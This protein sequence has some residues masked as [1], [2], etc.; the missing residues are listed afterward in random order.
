MGFTKQKL[1]AGLPAYGGWVM[2]AHP[3]IIELYAGEHFDWICLDMEHTSI[4]LRSM[5]ECILAAKGMEVDVLVR[6]PSHEPSIAKRVLDAG[7]AGIIIPCI[8]SAEQARQAVAMTKYPPEGNRGTS[9]SRNTDF[10]RNFKDHF[11]NHNEKVIVVI[12]LEHVEALNHLEEILQVP[13]IDATFIGPY[14]LST[15]MGLSGQ[16]DHP[17]VVAAQQRILEACQKYGVPAGY[18]VVQPNEKLVRQRVEEGFCFIGCG[19]DTEFIIH[20]CRKM[21]PSTNKIT[22]KQNSN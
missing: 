19:L 4:D 17:K 14:D 15:S 18:H 13:G 21:I 3:T 1:R 12:M 7:A 22:T 5:H 16:L 11:E 10:G 8:N 9:L 2:I 6:L 20:G